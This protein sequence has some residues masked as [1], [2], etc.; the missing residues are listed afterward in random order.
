MLE[1]TL[2][3]PLDCKEIKPVS[4]KGNQPWIFTGKLQYFGHPMWRTD[5]LEKILTLGN[6]R[7]GGEGG[8]RGWDGWIASPT[9]WT[10]VWAVSGDSEGQETRHAAALGVTKCRTWLINWI[11]TTMRNSDLKLNLDPWEG[12]FIP[13]HSKIRVP[14]QYWGFFFFF[15]PGL[16][17]LG[18]PQCQCSFTSPESLLLVLP[19]L[20]NPLAGNS[21]THRQFW[22][23]STPECFAFLCEF[24]VLV[25]QTLEKTFFNHFV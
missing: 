4:P 11:T 25:H 22:E 23:N 24:S 12:P 16:I 5:S 8:D 7:A 2:K 14:T 3:S 19:K 13:I 1:K 10:C 9:Q 21:I 20:L 18:K 17:P 15:E 6:L